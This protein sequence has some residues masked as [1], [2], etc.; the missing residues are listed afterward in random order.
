MQLTGAAKDFYFGW[1]MDGV[2]DFNGDGINDV[3]VGERQHAS[4]SISYRGAAYLL[5]G[6]SS[7][8]SMSMS[9]F[10]TGPLGIRFLGVAASE[11]AGEWV[12]GAGDINGDGKMDI[13]IG[14]NQDL[15]SRKG[16]GKVYVVYGT[17]TQFSADINLGT[18]LA[19]NLGFTIYGGVN[20]N[21]FGDSFS[22]GGD[23]DQDGYD[24]FVISS[25]NSIFVM[26]LPRLPLK[27]SI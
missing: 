8:A 13:L 2:G 3:L 16:V 22:R 11:M 19:A 27:T 17:S 24:D 12:S 15:P 23:L 4:D 1:S 6:S 25:W 10:V 18:L 26:D 5:Y 7:L 9:S 21:Y 14:G 20:F